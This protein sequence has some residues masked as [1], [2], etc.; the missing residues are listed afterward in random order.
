MRS[1]PRPSTKQK[2]L[3]SAQD[4]WIRGLNTLVSSTQIKPNELAQASDIMLVED[5]K[6]KCPRDGQARY[7]NT[8][9]SRTTGLFT[10]YKSDGTKKLLRSSGTHLQ[11]FNTSTSDWDNV[12]GY[13]YTTDLSTDG[14]TAY[15]RLYIVNGT[16][17]LTYYDGTSITSFTA[18][19]D[20]AAP[21]PTR[22]GSSGTYTFSYKI[23]AVTAVGETAASASGSTTLNQSTL[24]ASNYMTVAWSAVTNA[25]GYNV[26]GRTDGNWTFIKY[27][28]GNGS[29]S[30]V[31]KGEITPSEVFTPPESNST[32][33]PVGTTVALYKDTIFVLGDPENPSRLYY[34]G[35]G[36]KINDFSISNGGGFI[37]ISKNDGQ[38]G[39][40][41]IVF[42]DSLLVFKERSLYQFNFT[43]SGLPQVTQVNPA[44]GCI[45]P[46]GVV[47]VENDV[48]FPSE[49]GIFTVGNEA[50]FAFD[51]LRTNEL[52]SRVRSIYQ[53]IDPAYIQNTSAVYATK[54]NS[55][56]VIFA[57]T[58][59]GSTT[60]S[61]AIVYDRERLGWYQWSTMTAN[62]WVNYTDSTGTQHT[63]YGDDSGGYV[64]EIL[65]GSD[66]FGTAIQGTFALRS[67]D[68]KLG[69]AQYKKLK[70]LS[71]VLR[72]PT[73][74]VSLTV[75]KDGTDTSLSTNINTVNP[76]INWGHYV[77]QDF[78]FGES[79]GTGAVTTSDDIVLRTKKN[80][81]LQGRTFQLV[82]TNG[83]GGAHFTLLQTQ[84]TAKPRNPRYRMSSDLIT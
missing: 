74:T 46:K 38:K 4:S 15:D 57:Y 16:D 69:L 18:I 34:S 35:G 32:A 40:K 61:A 30:F 79:S 6:V 13:T 17:P 55:N 44:I 64:N 10:Y 26:Y 21:T 20:P 29:V 41:T 27:L 60:N 39:T 48:F 12:S 68:F 73:G 7:G 3:T 76:S 72:Q 51:V 50:G 58:P 11:V 37:D 78:L 49:R 54:G 83:T 42:K 52:S 67:E 8:S 70:D 82:F 33:G 24:D 14:V 36:D 25:I 66:D 71:I 5:G 65:T 80:L 22:T 47:A 31:D 56:L 45:A 23:T 62:C 53:S 59:S 63:L 81:N 9:G 43:T 28:E 19:S 84:V 75:I 2:I 1:F 77:I